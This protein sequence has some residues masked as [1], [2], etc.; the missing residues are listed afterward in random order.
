MEEKR[1][2]PQTHVVGQNSKTNS[3]RTKRK[4]IQQYVLV[5]RWE[6]LKTVRA[7]V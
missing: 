7:A 3:K 4:R 5:S 1:K 2:L 6:P